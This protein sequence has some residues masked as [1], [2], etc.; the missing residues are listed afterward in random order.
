MRVDHTQKRSGQSQLSFRL[1]EVN[2]GLDC[3][4]VWVMEWVTVPWLANIKV[5]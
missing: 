1:S 2:W 5:Q 3:A 4:L